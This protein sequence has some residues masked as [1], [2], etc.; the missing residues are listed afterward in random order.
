MLTCKLQRLQE[1]ACQL[2]G[3]SP[4]LSAGIIDSQSVKTDVEGYPVGIVV[5]PASV[6]NRDGPPGVVEGALA[7]APE[8]TRIWA[9]SGD[10]PPPDWKRP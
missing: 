10:M 5:H 3:R 8:I 2:D 7:K 1:V 9:D 4:S 6:Q